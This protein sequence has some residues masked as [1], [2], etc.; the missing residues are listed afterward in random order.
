[1]NNVCPT[2]K[3]AAPKFGA[4]FN[5]LFLCTLFDEYFVRFIVNFHDVKSGRY[6]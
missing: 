4:A 2:T 5:F 3:K 6:V 1:M